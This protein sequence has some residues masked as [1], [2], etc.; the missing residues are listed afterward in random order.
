VADSQTQKRPGP[1]VPEIGGAPRPWFGTPLNRSSPL[2]NLDLDGCRRQSRTRADRHTSRV[3]SGVSA[4]PPAIHV[5]PV[6]LA[7]AGISLT[8]RSS[9]QCARPFEAPEYVSPARPTQLPSIQI[10]QASAQNNT[11]IY[12]YSFDYT[13][14]MSGKRQS[15]GEVLFALGTL[16]IRQRPRELSLTALSTLSTIERTGPRRLT[17]LAISEGV[18]QPSM[19]ALIN[20][21]ESLGLVERQPDVQDG[22]VVRVTI[23]PAGLEHLSTLRRVGASVFEV[24]ID[25]LASSEAASLRAA[26][27]AFRRMLELADEESVP[28]RSVT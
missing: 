17:D 2:T 28:E 15:I 27:P 7:G 25:K 19:S 21:L 12:L 6:V 4:S 20:Q 18:T 22:R 1:A 13:R 11:L 3:I 10:A 16:G 23:T 5:A 9:M 26:L 8:L 14:C 24:L